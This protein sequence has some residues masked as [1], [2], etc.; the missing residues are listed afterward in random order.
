[1]YCIM[2]CFKKENHQ[3]KT[4]P[5][6]TAVIELKSE[7]VYHKSNIWE[8]SLRKRWKLSQFPA[9]VA[10]RSDFEEY[11]TF[12]ECSD[13]PLPSNIFI[14]FEIWTEWWI[15]VFFPFFFFLFFIY[16]WVS[17]CF[18]F[19]IFFLFFTFLQILCNSY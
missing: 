3:W 11:Q 4:L 14:W 1:M 17:F 5:T 18:T 2:S 19:F 8:H 13:A 10:L 6:T 15:Y 16:T 12:S 9:I 7:A